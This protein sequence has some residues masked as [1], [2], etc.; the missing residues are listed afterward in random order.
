MPPAHVAY[1]GQMPD[2]GT[3]SPITMLRHLRRLS[4]KGWEVSIV[5]ENGQAAPPQ[6]A[7][8]W[9]VHHLSLRKPWWPPFRP[10]NRF[11]RNLRMQLWAG[12][13]AG[14]FPPPQAILTYLSF[15]SEMHSEVAAHYARR[16]GAPLSVIVHDYPPD[17]PGFRKEDAAPL[18][19]RQHWILRHAR[20][21]FFV[22]PELADCYDIPAEKKSVLMPIPE[23]GG[24]RACWRANFGARPLIVYAGFAYPAQMPLFAR[25]ARAIDGGGGRLLILSKKT[26]ELTA[27]CQNAPVE[28][29]DLFPTN[30]EALDFV[31]SQAAALLVSYS[32]ELAE[33]PWTKTSFPSKFVEFSHT[34]LPALIVAPG[35]SAIGL[36]AQRNAYPD[37]VLPDRMDSVAA[38][39]QALKEESAWNE[40]S[41][42]V[43]R[44]SQTEFNPDAIQA[45]LEAKLA[46]S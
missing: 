3:G 27:L 21:V 45:A 26:P 43:T 33:M 30:G 34:G 5:G 6:D 9:A 36:W 40:K 24:V 4:A 7:A 44:F 18:L 16:C 22:S 19:Q 13:C 1:F 12:E 20:H 35:Q 28:Q 32:E 14:F 8:R 31:R 37:F 29:R 23:G 15:Y 39:V 38:F 10:G 42:T 17:F 2:H 25:L 11:L 46:A 41:A